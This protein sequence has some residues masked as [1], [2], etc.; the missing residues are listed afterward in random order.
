VFHFSLARLTCCVSLGAILTA[1]PGC[2]GRNG[3][4]TISH[5]TGGAGLNGGTSM[6]TNSGGGDAASSESPVVGGSRSESGG[7][8]GTGGAVSRSSSAGP[9]AGASSGAVVLGGSLSGGT[10]V[11]GVTSKGGDTGTQVITPGGTMAVGRYSSVGTPVDAGTSDAA[12]DCSMAYLQDAVTHSATRGNPGSCY[13][14]AD[15]SDRASL[16][17][18][19]GSIVIDDSGYVSVV[20]G[21]ASGIE[22]TLRNNG[23]ACRQLVGLTLLYWCTIQI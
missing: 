6:G 11:G 7:N 2:S 5:S 3:L 1:G 17:Q 12:P 23:W 18:P 16:G 13:V 20:T 19:W 9:F 15:P 4:S 21:P 14:S 10:G 22:V 8:T